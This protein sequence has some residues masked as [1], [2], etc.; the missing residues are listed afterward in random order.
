[1]IRIRPDSTFSNISARK[2]APEILDDLFHQVKIRLKWAII[3]FFRK[4]AGKQEILQQMF[5]KF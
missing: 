4:E 2:K 5:R 3:P 1:M